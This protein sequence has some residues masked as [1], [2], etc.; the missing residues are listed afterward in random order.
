MRGGR[1]GHRGRVDLAE[2]GPSPGHIYAAARK[3][4]SR[5]MVA[6][7]IEGNKLHP[8]SVRG[9]TVSEASIEAFRMSTTIGLKGL[10]DNVYVAFSHPD[11]AKAQAAAREIQV[12]M[13][14]SGQGLQ[15]ASMASLPLH[16]ERRGMPLALFAGIVT[17]AL[18]GFAASRI[19]RRA[20]A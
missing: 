2:P 9:Q 11:P 7:F 3:A 13:I 18:T 12:A 10:T 4:L 5:E 19:L 8:G 6:G 14:D 1:V 17:G 20:R 16:S 15:V